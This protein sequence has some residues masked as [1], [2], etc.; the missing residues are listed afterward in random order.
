MNKTRKAIIP[1]LICLLIIGS[2]IGG[3]FIW[4]H[5]ELYIGSDNAL[6][7]A[8][9]D[10]GLQRASVHDVDVD[11]EKERSS[12]WYDVE[13]ETHALKYDYIIDAATGEILYNS[14]HAG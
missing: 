11:F 13:F 6:M 8:L 12:A 5:N 3:Y 14:E 9:A 2:G 10:A 1:V 4:R 7:L